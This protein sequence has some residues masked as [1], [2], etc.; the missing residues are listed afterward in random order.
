MNPALVTVGVGAP[1]SGKAQRLAEASRRVSPGVSVLSWTENWPDGSPTHAQSPYAFKF[2]ALREAAIRA[3][4]VLLW[5]DS[6]M[7][8][9]RDYTPMLDYIEQRG[10]LFIPNG[11]SV[12]QWC[13]DAALEKLG[14]SREEAMSMPDIVGGLFGLDIRNPV[15]RD[16]LDRMLELSMDGV[17]FPGPW[18][19]RDGE[20]S[21]DLRVLGHRHDQTAMSV[22][23]IQMGMEW[24]C[25]GDPWFFYPSHGQSPGDSVLFTIR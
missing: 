14:V 25:E 17:T 24:R 9:I 15:A 13:K 2:F 21:S 8:P 3:N 23:R 16:F 4:D 12:G 22:V 20:C 19:N 7:L 5:A 6:A 10:W 18:T 1:F 11:W